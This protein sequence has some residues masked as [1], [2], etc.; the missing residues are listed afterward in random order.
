[1]DYETGEK[2]RHSHALSPPNIQK[3]NSKTP[4]AQREQFVSPRDQNRRDIFYSTAPS[5]MTQK[6]VSSRYYK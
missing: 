3:K 6:D 5:I 1:M 2:N 4:E